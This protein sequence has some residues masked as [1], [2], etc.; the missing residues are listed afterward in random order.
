MKNSISSFGEFALSRDEQR[1]ISGGDSMPVL[2]FSPNTV[3]IIDQMNGHSWLLLYN[4]QTNVYTN[5]L[6]NTM[7][8][9]KSGYWCCDTCQNCGGN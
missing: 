4:T 3:K 2:N 8:C 7:Y 1:G 6:G 5:M 9:N